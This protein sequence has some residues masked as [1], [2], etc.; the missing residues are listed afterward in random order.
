MQRLGYNFSAK[1]KRNEFFADL[2]GKEAAGFLDNGVSGLPGVPIDL[3][4]RMGM[5][6][7]IPG[8]GLMTKKTDYTRDVIELAGPAG[9]LIKRGLQSINAL[10]SGEAGKAVNTL[11]PVAGRNL[12]QALDMANTGMY[13]DTTGKKVLDVDGYDMLA[14]AIGFQPN[15]VARV[16]ESSRAVQIMISQNKIRE[17]EIA[18][19]WAQGQF[20]K[21]PDKVADARAMLKG[22]NENNPDSQ[23]RINMMQIAKRVNAMRQSKEER[24]AK[25]APKEIRTAVRRELQQDHQ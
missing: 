8:S 7:L 6:N 13:R 17:T 9:D 14:K 23:I 16:Q 18:D 19:K 15:D 4:G 24:I 5:G 22:W 21:D 2:L 10:A 20:E 11:L 12:T 3:S 25:T 1:Q